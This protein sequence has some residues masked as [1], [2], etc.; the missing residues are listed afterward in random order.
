MATPKEIFEG[1]IK[2]RISGD[3]EKSKSIGA[4]YKFNVT[5]DDGGTWVINLKDNPGVSEGDAP[6]DCTITV[7][8][9]DFVDIV[10]GKLSAQM[11]FMQGKLKIA[12]NMGLAM[13]LGQVLGG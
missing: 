1:K 13:K 7:G 3:P 10:S 11:A 8:S 4:V 6:A 2:E 12:G 5:G 9:Q